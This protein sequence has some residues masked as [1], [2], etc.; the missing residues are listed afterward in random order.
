[1][2]QQIIFHYGKTHDPDGFGK[3]IEEPNES[4]KNTLDLR[5]PDSE[6]SAKHLMRIFLAE[7]TTN[8]M[9]ANGNVNAYQVANVFGNVFDLSKSRDEN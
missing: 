3:W 5:L 1:M 7:L 4:H 8:V 2:L 9:A 6:H